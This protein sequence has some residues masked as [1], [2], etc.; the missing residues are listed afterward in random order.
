MPGVWAWTNASC[1]KWVS[2][3]TLTCTSS[4]KMNSRYVKDTALPVWFRTSVLEELPQISGVLVHVEPEEEL[5]A[6]HIARVQ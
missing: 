1:G 4:L 5:T 2:V 3:S 6:K